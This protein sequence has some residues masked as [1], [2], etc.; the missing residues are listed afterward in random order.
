MRVETSKKNMSWSMT[1]L[2]PVIK[3]YVFLRYFKE[4]EGRN[5]CTGKQL[6]CDFMRPQELFSISHENKPGDFE[7]T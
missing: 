1:S 4:E 2:L 3:P 7:C 5:I 6:G